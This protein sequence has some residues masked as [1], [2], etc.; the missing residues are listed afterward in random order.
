[1]KNEVRVGLVVIAGAALIVLGT[2][3]LQDFSFGSERRDVD[4]WFREVGQL[5]QGNAVKLGGPRASWCVS[6]S[7]RTWCSR[8]TRW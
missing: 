8:R 2:L 6:T 7:G 5:Q 1:M 3:W 4:A